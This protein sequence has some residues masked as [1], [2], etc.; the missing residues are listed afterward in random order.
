M[1]I[2]TVTTT[3]GRDPEQQHGI[4]NPPVYHASTVLFPT[5]AALKAAQAHRFDG[6]YYGRYGTPTTFALEEAIAA[7]DGGHRTHAVSSGLAALTVSLMAFVRAGDHVLVA[8]NVY[9][10]T[11][12]V[13]NQLLG[14]FGVTATYYDPAIGGRIAELMQPRTRLVFAETPG[15]L[16]F[17]MCDLPAI[18]EAAHTQGAV[19]VADNT[20]A[21]P[22]YFKPLAHGADVALMAATKYIGGHS[23]LMMGLITANEATVKQVQTTIA[24][25]GCASGPDDCYLALRGLRTL[26]VRMPRHMETGLRLARWLQARPEVA[27]VLH[28][29]LP[30]DP[31]HTLWRR[32]FSGASGLFS[33]VLKPVDPAALTAMLDGMKLFG[34]GYS[35]G[36]YESLIL[37]VDPTRSRT[38]VP[39]QAEG[40]LLRLHAGLEDPED[41]IA[42]LEAGFARLNAAAGASP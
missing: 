4:V 37:W 27:R 36:G 5:V 14:R 10:P 28:P 35:W 22:Y 1:R 40:P 42:D 34:M 39:W 29:A 17:E 30:D 25:L 21:T 33:V 11:R 38:A 41:L 24:D 16:T 23:D 3:A 9:E 31:G 32:H 20:W 12:R 13:A 8:D 6:V 15:S 2:D 18:A 26:A 19:V 7:L